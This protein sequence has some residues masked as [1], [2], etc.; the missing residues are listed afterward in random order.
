[1]RE[2]SKLPPEKREDDVLD[3]DDEAGDRVS[4]RVAEDEEPP[5]VLRRRRQQPLVVGVAADDA[6]EDDDVGGLDPG[7][8]DRCR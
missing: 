7:G 2:G 3:A 4:A 6:V 5:R 1:M 8:L